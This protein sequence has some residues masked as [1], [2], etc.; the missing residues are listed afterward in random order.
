MEYPGLNVELASQ[1]NYLWWFYEHI[2][3][4]INITLSRI[5]PSSTKS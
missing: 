3:S 2:F 5:I 4:G 1:L